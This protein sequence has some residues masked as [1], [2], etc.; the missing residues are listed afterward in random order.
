MNQILCQLLK[1]FCAWF[2]QVPPVIVLKLVH[3]WQI[4]P[5]WKFKC[6]NSLLWVNM[7]TELLKEMTTPTSFSREKGALLAPDV[8][9]NSSPF[10]IQI[11]T[12]KRKKNRGVKGS[13]ILSKKVMWSGVWL[14]RCSEEWPYTIS[15]C[16]FN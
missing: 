10:P 5:A 8:S 2:E 3:N 7:Q 11:L 12:L 13:V 9:S 1:A 14:F 16:P 6:Q 4:Q 15:M